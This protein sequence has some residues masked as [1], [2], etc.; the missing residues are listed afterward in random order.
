MLL[1]G[2]HCWYYW[3]FL[4]DDAL[5]S[6]R[7]A[8]R[9][10]DGLGLTW[11]A[12]EQVEGYSNLLWVLLTAG[13]HSLGMDLIVA[14]RM[15]GILGTALV[16]GA[17]IFGNK[18]DTPGTLKWRGLAAAVFVSS[19]PVAI[20]TIG[21]LETMLYA[22]LLAIAIVFSIR[23]IQENHRPT[24]FWLSLVLGLLC[25]TR[26][27]GPLLCVAIMSS[28]LLGR[29]FGSKKL[30]IS[31]ALLLVIPIFPFLFYGAQLLFRLRYYG[32]WLPNTALVK[33]SPSGYHLLVGGKYILKFLATM[34]MVI[35]LGIIPFFRRRKKLLQF[36]SFYPL[37]L[38]SMLWGTYV[39]MIGGDYFP[40]FR[41]A[42]PLI[43]VIAFAYREIN[44][45]W[46]RTTITPWMLKGGMFLFLLCLILTQSFFPENDRAKAERWEWDSQ[47]LAYALTD[48][49]GD[50]NPL[51][52]VTAAGSI[53]YWTGF[54]A[55]DLHGLNDYYLPR[56]KPDNYENTRVGHGLSDPA[57]VLSRQPDIVIF[58]AGNPDP[59]MGP[60]RDL[61]DT[62]AFREQYLPVEITGT[63][64][65][66]YRGTVWIRS[67]F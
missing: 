66:E 10:V 15:L 42:L 52:A 33:L 55:I 18:G 54:E 59:P 20:W 21:G 36:P 63:V 47:V 37:V 34:S 49:Y 22:G 40:G 50:R 7:Y 14:A 13:L 35:L 56:H 26:P 60:G 3:P 25:L 9:L 19:G 62:P 38:I 16:V 57:Y 31:W 53:P 51:I 44:D 8:D 11:T 45:S 67:G 58:D 43:V 27:D 65:Y 39:L 48:Q 6:L 28:I 12:G 2:I 29:R 23:L 41:Q 24:V 61:L 17:L 32:E 30:R 64:P 1:L 46:F 5:I 4:S